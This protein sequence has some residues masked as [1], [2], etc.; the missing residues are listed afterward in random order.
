MIPRVLVPAFGWKPTSLTLVAMVA[1][2]SATTVA[3]IAVWRAVH[4]EEVPAA[5]ARP[6]ASWSNSVFA[7]S[8]SARPAGEGAPVLD[9][10]PFSAD[11][12]LAVSR[13]VVASQA[14]GSV[15]P[16]LPPEALRLLGTVLRPE[17]RSFVVYQLPSEVPR[18]AHVGESVGGMTLVNVAPGRATF[19]AHT[20]ALVDLSLR[21]PGS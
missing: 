9:N 18:T 19:R 5:A 2:I 3:A 17:G 13:A 7:A 6:D 8:A 12:E 10:D 1:L 15:V 16:T 11:R 20:G 21:R 4:L 14:A